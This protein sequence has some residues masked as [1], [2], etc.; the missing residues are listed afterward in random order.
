MNE[1]ELI[2]ELTSLES[3]KDALEIK[4]NVWV[5]NVKDV[6][7]KERLVEVKREIIRVSSQLDTFNNNSA[8]LNTRS[9][10][11][12]HLQAYTAAMSIQNSGYN[13]KVSRS[14]GFVQENALLG[15]L[16]S[17]IKRFVSG[18][19]SVS[20]VSPLYNSGTEQGFI[21]KDKL[22]FFLNNE[23]Q[24]VADIR[25]VNY[26]KLRAFYEGFRKALLREFAT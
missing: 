8:C 16:L 12:S 15:D 6:E 2:R 3:E 20:Q 7:F 4:I 9:S 25:E 18:R 23:I 19:D 5:D 14:Q 21:N 13:R 22:T 11:I 1:L 24:R 17:D 26:N 10:I